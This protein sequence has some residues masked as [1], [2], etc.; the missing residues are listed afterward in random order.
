MTPQNSFFVFSADML[1]SSKFVSLCLICLSRVSSMLSCA[2]FVS[3]SSLCV[4]FAFISSSFSFV[5]L[6]FLCVSLLLC[7]FSVSS[8]FFSFPC[9]FVSLFLV[10]GL[11]SNSFPGFPSS[12]DVLS[13]LE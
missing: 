6:S 7:L 5:P 8:V 13:G 10:G 1:Q 2:F 3:L 9:L 11:G 4:H 12:V